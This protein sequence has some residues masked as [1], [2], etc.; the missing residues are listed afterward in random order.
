MDLSNVTYESISYSL[1]YYFQVSTHFSFPHWRSKSWACGTG[2]AA[3]AA[4]LHSLSAPCS[5]VALKS[6]TGNRL[7]TKLQPLK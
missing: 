7:K 6:D 5:P 3:A 1:E 2:R 4:K